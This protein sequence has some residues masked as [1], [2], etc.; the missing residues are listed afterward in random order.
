MSDGANNKFFFSLSSARPF[1]LSQGL[2]TSSSLIKKFTNENPSNIGTFRLITKEFDFGLPSVNKKI[3]KV[4]VT[5]KNKDRHGSYADSGVKVYYGV[6]G[7][8]ITTIGVG[9]TFDTSKSRHYSTVGGLTA[10]DSKS[11]LNT[12]LAEDLTDSETDITLASVANVH[13]TGALQI[14]NEQILID[15]ETTINT[16]TNTISGINVNLRG[17]YTTSPST[18]SNN[19]TVL[20]AR[21][22][23]YFTA[24]L[25]PSE[26]INNVKSFQLKFE[27]FLPVPAQ[28]EIN[29]ITIVYRSKNIR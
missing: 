29:D 26:S 3:Y 8:D 1:L 25:R 12:T 21:T 4:Y 14:N 5:F 15:R 16:S 28:F 24:E 9:S 6:N 2:V 11:S 17:Y 22:D 18:H 13:Q 27:S 10:F 20:V 7:K 23:Q 19:D